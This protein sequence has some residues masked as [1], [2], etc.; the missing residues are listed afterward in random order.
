MGELGRT[1]LVAV[2]NETLPLLDAFQPAEVNRWGETVLYTGQI[3]SQPVALA[4]VLPGPVNGALGA[5]ALLARFGVS[6]L[7]SVGSAGALDPLLSPGDLVIAEQAIAHDAGAFLGRRF[8]PGGIIGRDHR[9][10][11]GHRRFFQADPDLV[12]A[13]QA[14]SSATAGPQDSQAFVGTVVTGNQMICSTARK[15]WLHR[16]FDAAAVEMETAA[17]AQVAVAH[18]VPWVA[19]RGISDRAGDDL[20]LDYHRLRIYLDDG[21]PPWRHFAGRWF[22]LLTHPRAFGRMRRLRRGL[23][24]ASGRASRVVVAMLQV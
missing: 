3:A 12:A 14:M 19:V 24:L 1:G 8:E 4:Q 10:R 18:G 9:G 15:R 5:Q 17:V 22:Y 7:I 20:I 6:R 23:A 13:A 21:R 2:F 11:V 16:T